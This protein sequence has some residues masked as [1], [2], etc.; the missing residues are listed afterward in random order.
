M[1]DER[2]RCEAV[3]GARCIGEDLD[4]LGQ[5]LVVDALH[6][7]RSVVLGRCTQDDLFSSTFDVAHSGFLGEEDACTLT[8]DVS[9]ETAPLDGCR[10]L[11]VENLDGL[12]THSDRIIRK[13]NIIDFAVD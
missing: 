5:V 9:A 1:H 2:E 6:E 12:A 11:F 7:H 8:H 10:G 4:V 3:G 13:G